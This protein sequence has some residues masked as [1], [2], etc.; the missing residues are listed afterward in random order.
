MPVFWRVATAFLALALFGTCASAEEP[1]TTGDAVEPRPVAAA[2]DIR[3]AD[4]RFAIVGDRT[5]GHRPGV[6]A[7]A[8]DKLELLQPDF[9]VSVGDLIEGY[10]GDEAEIRRQWD[11]VEDRL[12]LLTMPVFAVPGNHDYSNAAMARIWRERR[13][14]PYWAFT[15][16]GVL[17][18]GLSTEDPPVPQSAETLAS[19]LELEQAMARDPEATQA[20][21]LEAVK[22]RGAPPK[23]PGSVNISQ[24]QI[25]FVRAALAEYPDARWTF[26]I[27]HK[28]AW[29]Y[30]SAEFAAIEA[31]LSDRPYTVVAGHEH[32]YDHEQRFGRDYIVMGTTGGVWLR[33]GPGRVDHLALVTLRDGEPVFVNLRT[34]GMFGKEGQSTPTSMPE[35]AVPSSDQ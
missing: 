25:G 10:T 13:G 31:M 15:H 30:R 21:L 27:M 22:A 19:T 8:V 26:V 33:D 9:V 5:G 3:E 16:K 20:R 17:F 24:E 34:D 32:Y 29:R 18:L 6:F 14:A 35:S 23:L 7:R 11:E 12:S 4:F 2:E 28:P 1:R